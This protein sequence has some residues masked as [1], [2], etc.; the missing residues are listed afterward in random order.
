MAGSFE[1]LQTI[2]LGLFDAPL[3]RDQVRNL[4]HDNVVAE[5]AKT[6]AD[7][8]ISPVSM[9]SVL[10]EYL[11]RYRPSGQFEALTESAKNLKA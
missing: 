4:G 7:L 5:G 8:G 6:F 9:E 3:T 10:P 11:W 2:S 1:L